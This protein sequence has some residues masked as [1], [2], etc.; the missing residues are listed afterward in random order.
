MPRLHHS[1]EIEVRAPAAAAFAIVERDILAV[2]DEPG[3]ISGH[4]P[5]SEGALRQGFRW[6]QW[7]MHERHACFTQWRIT[8][9]ERARL[10]EQESWH[11]CAVEQTDSYGGERWDFAERGD[12]TTV[13]TLSAWRAHP[14]IAGWLEKLLGD[15]GARLAA[16]SIRR[17]LNFVQ[18]EAER[19]EAP[20][21]A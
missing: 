5:M 15:S 3:A 17:R 13:V 18:F 9:V 21:A 20:A 12:G 4:R 6:Q 19:Y 14:G 10:L 8:A 7:G 1:A 2:N 16:Y 11:F